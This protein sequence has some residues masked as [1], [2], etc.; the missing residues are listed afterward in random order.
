VLASDVQ[1]R[2]QVVEHVA[3]GDGLDA[4]VDPAGTHHDRHA[5]GEV[6]DH[7]ERERPG[8]DDDRGAELGDGDT[9]LP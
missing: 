6:A 2:D 8:A 1:G 4:G 9:G 3:D 7:L 5:L